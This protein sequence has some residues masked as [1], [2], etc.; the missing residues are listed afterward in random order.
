ME[1]PLHR[2]ILEEHA[3]NPLHREKLEGV[4]EKG[5]WKSSRTG[6]QC[7]VEILFDNE[8]IED[9]RAKVD[10]SA[11]AIACAS[12]MAS[13]IR[14][15]L[16][17]DALALG[18]SVVTYLEAGTE[19]NLPG[20]LVVYESIARFPELPRLRSLGLAG[21]VGGLGFLI[22]GT[23]GIRHYRNHGGSS[24]LA[25]DDGR[26]ERYAVRSEPRGVP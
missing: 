6:N 2:E 22:S 12:L 15:S 14:G 26:S 9:M 24:H 10:G 4:V 23:L 25:W 18:H 1:D 7:S 17:N 3:R 5:E 13:E 16:R 20:D 19:T 21:L 8:S 11:L